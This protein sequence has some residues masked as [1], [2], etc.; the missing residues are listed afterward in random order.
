[1]FKKKN[2]LFMFISL[3]AG[4]SL[5]YFFD[6]TLAAIFLVI[7]FDK[8]FLGM[9]GIVRCF[10]IEFTTI[11]TILL[12]ITHGPLFAFV[13]ALIVIPIMHGIKYLF[14]PLPHPEWPLFV[15]SPY[16]FVDALGAAI[17]GFLASSPIL[18]I[19][20]AVLIIK[21]ITYAL[22]DKLFFSKPP[23]VIYAIGN[24][25]FN[26]IIILQF[27]SFFLELIA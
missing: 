9:L 17:A 26:F 8:V 19:L 24:F 18:Y 13:F 16:N 22:A 7:W 25:I 1:M 27:G 20:I 10:G 4:Y 5:F 21:D 11:A 3:I 15:P 6:V 14:L 12:G 2:I 23:E